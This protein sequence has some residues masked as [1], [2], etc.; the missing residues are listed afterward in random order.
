[1]R[2]IRKDTDPDGVG[3]PHRRE[4]AILNTT[5]SIER[6]HTGGNYG[7]DLDGAVDGKDRTKALLE[8]PPAKK[9]TSNHT[10]DRIWV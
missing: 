9:V 5:V 1:M 7:Y 10:P 8:R 4:V 3:S 2:R 6:R